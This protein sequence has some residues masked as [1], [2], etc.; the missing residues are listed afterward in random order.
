[1]EVILSFL[2]GLE[3]ETKESFEN[4]AVRRQTQRIRR[5]AW[6]GSD[7]QS[8]VNFVNIKNTDGETAIHLAARNENPNIVI[9]LLMHSADVMSV[10]GK[11]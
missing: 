11:H 2:N 3:G 9:I 6:I 5:Q 1:M 4:I 10:Y 8:T 7:T